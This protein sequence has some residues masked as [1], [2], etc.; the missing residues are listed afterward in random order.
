[1]IRALIATSAVV[2]A[3]GSPPA[4]LPQVPISNAGQGGQASPCELGWLEQAD[5][6]VVTED[7]N[8]HFGYFELRAELRVELRGGELAG[9]VRAS[10]KEFP[11][12]ARPRGLPTSPRYTAEMSRSLQA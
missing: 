8:G 6:L 7:S 11:D 1:M 4:A 3:C 12:T 5:R 10:F 9:T 2:A